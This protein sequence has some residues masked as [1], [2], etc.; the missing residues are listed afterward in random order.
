MGMD[1]Q[2]EQ[3]SRR[4]LSNRTSL[5]TRGIEKLAIGRDTP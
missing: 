4:G 1:M 5:E 2:Q 3:L